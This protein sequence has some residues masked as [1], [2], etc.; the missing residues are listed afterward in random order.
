MS[1][2]ILNETLE[3]EEQVIETTVEET[4]QESALP[5]SEDD[6]KKAIQSASSKAKNEI[7]KEI[8]IEK[9]A[10]IKALIDKGNKYD[11]IYA[12]YE[13]LQSSKAE[14]EEK[15]GA[16][17]TDRI[18]YG[19]ENGLLK[20]GMQTKRLER[21]KSIIINDLQNGIE[22]DTAI[23]NLVNEF[24]EWLGGVRQVGADLTP[25]NSTLTE[26]EKYYKEMGYTQEK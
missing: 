19:I 3:V 7:L 5:T 6:F 12:E 8:G 10:D 21:A 4:T 15:L 11:E 13:Q 20:I 9:V 26:R 17:E 14:Y 25:D 18:N 22:L 1:N 24:P 16:L 23:N 2:E